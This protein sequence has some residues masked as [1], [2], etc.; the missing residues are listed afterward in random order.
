MLSSSSLRD[1]LAQCL[2]TIHVKGAARH[3]SGKVRENFWFDSGRMAIVVTDRVSVFDFKIGTIPYKGQVLNQLAAWWFDRL[4]EIAIP[5][6]LLAVPH[7]NVSVVRA[8][9]PL[10]IEMVIRAYLTGTTTTSSWYAYQNRDRLIC[11]IRMPEGMKKNERFPE[12]II[13]PTTKPTEGHDENVSR[14]DILARGLMTEDVLDRAED[15]ARRMFAHGQNVASER[16]LILVDTKY[17]MGLGQDGELI[18]IDEVHTPDSSRYWMAE[19]YAARMAAG[20]EPDGLDK[21]F[22]RR[23]IIDN[24]YR[25]GS[26]DHPARFL[27]DDI[28]VAAAEKYLRLYATV[29]GQAPELRAVREDELIGVLERVRAGQTATSDVYSLRN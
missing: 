10:P 14:A 18:V 16:G 24:G 23:M 28:R 5:H 13:T 15:Y 21:E 25:V 1:S 12:P 4:D 3:F 9:T 22:V 6:H 26:D 7:P 8:V 17:E 2:E 27:T 20:A 19:S 29:T 11:G